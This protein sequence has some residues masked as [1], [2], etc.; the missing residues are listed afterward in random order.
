MLLRQI[1]MA[2]VER[3]N[4]HEYEYEWLDIDS[5]SPSLLY[6]FYNSFLSVLEKRKY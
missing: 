6:L 5:K 2:T 4:I 3:G 1:H